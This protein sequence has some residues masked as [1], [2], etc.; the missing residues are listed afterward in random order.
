MHLMVHHNKTV[1]Y[2]QGEKAS[3]GPLSFLLMDQK[4]GHHNRAHDQVENHDCG[5]T[6][7]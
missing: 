7:C 2:F 1:C 6:L 3:T 5:F 4:M